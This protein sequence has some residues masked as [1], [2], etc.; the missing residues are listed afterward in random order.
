MV[1]CRN[2]KVVGRLFGFSA[3]SEGKRNTYK[4][5]FERER[6]R[7]RERE[8]ERERRDCTHVGPEMF[9]GQKN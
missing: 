5:M 9:R 7:D 2:C 3:W 4:V 6:E 1:S 8:R